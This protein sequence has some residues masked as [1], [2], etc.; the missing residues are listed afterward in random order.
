MGRAWTKWF[1]KRKAAGV[2]VQTRQGTGH[3]FG[4]LKGYVPLGR[5]E[6]ELYRALREALPMVDA[7]VGKLVRLTGGV[8]IRAREGQRGL[9]EFLRTVDVGRGT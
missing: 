4:I 1:E 8:R 7:A 2:T 9:E 3:P 6:M 5:G